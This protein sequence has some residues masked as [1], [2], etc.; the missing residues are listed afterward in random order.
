MATKPRR[1]RIPLPPLDDLTQSQLM[2]RRSDLH[3]LAFELETLLETG[4]KAASLARLVYPDWK[5]QMLTA[6]RM[7]KSM[8]NATERLIHDYDIRIDVLRTKAK[9]NAG[10]G[11]AYADDPQAG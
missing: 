7:Y 8:L 11:K 5:E 2:T 6:M 10:R 3:G 1:K 4:R 9:A